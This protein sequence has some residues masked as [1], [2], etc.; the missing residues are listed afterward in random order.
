MSETSRLSSIRVL[1]GAR[2]GTSS[3][4]VNTSSK[5]QAPGGV[6]T[7]S[8]VLQLQEKIRLQ[9]ELLAVQGSQLPSTALVPFGYPQSVV[10]GMSQSLAA[11]QAPSA[12]MVNL[13]PTIQAMVAQAMQGV[14]QGGPPSVVTSGPSNTAGR[15]N[16]YITE[17]T[18][19]SIE[20]GRNMLSGCIALWR[21]Q[22]ALQFNGVPSLDALPGASR[23]FWSQPVAVKSL[24]TT[25]LLFAL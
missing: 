24:E 7:N 10:P 13:L 25:V 8:Q 18:M 20:T 1:I 9:K 2:E 17:K 6:T 22:Q 19:V 16:K 11:F 12:G 4:H 15:P 23:I 3:R 14:S 5:G 21:K